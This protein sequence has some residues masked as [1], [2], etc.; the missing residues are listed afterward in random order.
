MVRT[1]FDRRKKFVVDKTYYFFDAYLRAI[2]RPRIASSNATLAGISR[3]K[4]TVLWIVAGTRDAEAEA[5]KPYSFSRLLR[6]FLSSFLVPR[7]VHAYPD[8]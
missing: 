6:H 5:R 1:P 8:N 7:V 4:P 3:L 2:A